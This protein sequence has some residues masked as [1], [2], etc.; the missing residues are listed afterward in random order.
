MKEG[1]CKAMDCMHQTAWFLDNADCRYLCYRRRT[2][3]DVIEHLPCR[4]I[5][6]DGDILES[7]FENI[8]LI[9]AVLRYIK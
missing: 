7:Q 6:S 8:K 4:Y 9:A 5:D 3:P 1:F 2:S